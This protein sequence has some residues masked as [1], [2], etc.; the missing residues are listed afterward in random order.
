[1]NAH[2][3]ILGLV[4]CAV[5]AGNGVVLA[6]ES[7]G[8]SQ[9]RGSGKLKKMDADSDGQVS[10]DEYLT[11]AE[12]RFGQMDANTDGYVTADELKDGRKAVRAKS[13]ERREHRQAEKDAE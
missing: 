12:H 4:A 7:E 2:T 6:Q 1:M 10:L 5:L 3:L 8:G 11:M 9:A 13:R